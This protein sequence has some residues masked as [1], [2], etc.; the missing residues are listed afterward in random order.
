LPGLQV[1]G[2]FQDLRFDW[3][4]D[5]TPAVASALESVAFLPKGFGGTLPVTFRVSLYVASAEYQTG[6]LLLSSEYSR[7]VGEF[8]SAAPKLLPPRTVNERYYVMA[9]YRM[10][11]WFTPGIYYSA[12]YPN[13]HQTS[14]RQNY[15]N[16]LAITAR[17]D[18][19]RHFLVKLEGHLMDGTA[20][21]DSGLNGGQDT[22]KLT[23]DWGVLLIKT[24]AFF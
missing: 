19:N 7:W 21:L 14:G 18:I 2:T 4:Y 16:D 13:V 8:D 20:D 17:Y 3:N 11:S 24:T 9:S 23:K 6:N 10:S 5:I 1:G 15:Q 22:S 12:Y